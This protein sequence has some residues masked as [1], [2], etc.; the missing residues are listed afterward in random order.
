MKHIRYW[1][2]WE[3]LGKEEK[4]VLLLTSLSGWP[5]KRERWAKRYFWL[6]SGREGRCYS[7]QIG[8]GKPLASPDNLTSMCT[9]AQGSP[10]HTRQKTQM[11]P[12]KNVLLLEVKHLI[13]FK[14]LKDVVLPCRLPQSASTQ[15]ERTSQDKHMLCNIHMARLA[16]M[17]IIKYKSWNENTSIARSLK[18]KDRQ[19]LSVVGR[20]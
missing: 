16:F 4:D 1:N 6:P 19:L 7:G 14:G 11:G 10:R 3:G 9:W 12:N 8:N 13:L 2:S 17:W 20:A 18:Q 5:D 15:Y